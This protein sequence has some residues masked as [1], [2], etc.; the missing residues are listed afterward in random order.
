MMHEWKCL[1][2]HY[3]MEMPKIW[4]YL[5]RKLCFPECLYCHVLYTIFSLC[6]K[7]SYRSQQPI[8][9]LTTLTFMF[10]QVCTIKPS[11][12]QDIGDTWSSLPGSTSSSSRLPFQDRPPFHLI[13]RRK[14]APFL[15]TPTVEARFSNSHLQ[16]FDR[17]KLI[18]KIIYV[19]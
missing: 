11:F 3:S 1:H 10:R 4:L 13:H 5:K 8:S 2:E 14:L 17:N 19:Y 18:F 12:F 9:V 6:C 7:H 16:L 15:I